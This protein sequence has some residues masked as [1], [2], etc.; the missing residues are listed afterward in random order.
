MNKGEFVD[1][2][3]EKTGMTKNDSKKALDAT[4]E[5]ITETLEE[6]DEVLLTGFGK[7]EPRARKATERVNPQTGEMIDVPAK[8]V[9][10][11]K[12]GKN[13]RETVEDN[14]EAVET[15]GGLKVEK[16]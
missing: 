8:V 6:G 13:L 14:L 2:L 7:F 5:V 1:R 12:K 15:E 16:S 11:F 3:A 4:I 10:R 9:P